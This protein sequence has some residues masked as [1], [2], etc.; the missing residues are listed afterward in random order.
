MPTNDPSTNKP[1]APLVPIKPT[2]SRL[3]SR[4]SRPETH[5]PRQQK[6]SR[7]KRR[8]VRSPLA[9][10]S[11][12]VLRL[13]VIGYVALLGTLVFMEDRL[14]YPGAYMSDR[15]VATVDSSIITV[16]YPSPGGITLS[17]RLLERPQSSYTILFFHGNGTKAKWLDVWLANLSAQCDATVMA[18]EYRGF[19][20]DLEPSERGVLDD[21][22]AARN[23][24][25][26][27]Y[28]LK[29]TD[30]VIYGRSLGG[31]CAVAVASMGGAKALV[32]ESTFDRLFNVA[33]GKYPFVPV[34]WLMRNRFDSV[35]KLTNYKGPLIQIHSPADTIIS[36]ERGLALYESAKSNP[37][38]FI[39]IEGF[40]HNEFMPD[41]M[42]DEVKA[43]LD[44]F[45]GS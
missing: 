21:C 5:Q 9:R 41:R 24:L 27:R 6:A 29:P 45:T 30:I 14:V 4:P 26:E 15:P 42:L 22:F 40:D 17:G 10:F 35:A 34:R 44:E 33:A 20:D 43:K 39:N 11:I 13:I 7:K 3:E 2:Q 16:S 12:A 8:V 38:V 37:K 28:D 19:E 1:L 32:L 25:C 23:F 36:I 18:A 31:G